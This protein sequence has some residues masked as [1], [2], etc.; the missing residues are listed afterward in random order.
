MTFG[1]VAGT[2]VQTE[3]VLQLGCEG[4]VEL[5]FQR[6]VGQKETLSSPPA[7]IKEREGVGR[8]VGCTKKKKKKIRAQAQSG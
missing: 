2:L 5:T 6:K 3:W 7:Y 8:W 1:G 4:I